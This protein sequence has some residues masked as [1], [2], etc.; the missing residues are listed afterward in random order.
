MKRLYRMALWRAAP[1]SMA[2]SLALGIVAQAPARADA[3]A[4]ELLAKTT[5]A[6]KAAKSLTA[7]ISITMS[8]GA[9]KFAQTGTLRLRKP[10]LAHVEM[11]TPVKMTIM[12]DGKSVYT[13]LADKQYVQQP[14][15]S[16]GMAQVESRV[17]L[18]AA[19][20]FG[21]DSYGF[22]RLS[23]PATQKKYAGKETVGGVAYDVVTV[24]GKTPFVHTLKI[25]IGPDGLIGRSSADVTVQSKKLTQNF[26]WKSLKLNAVPA[27]ASF[28][29]VLPKDA[30]PY[31]PPSQDDYAA[32]LVAV[33]M[34]APVFALPNPTGGTVSLADSTA[35]HKA[36]IVNFWFYG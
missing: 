34:P 10:N 36:V 3:K 29:V 6:Y 33:G 8:Q 35:D 9:Q 7:D 12:S 30:K 27:A 4:D 28:A 17:G 2:A 31:K 23:D 15:D 24:S 32:K 14:V 11:L 25:Y 22:G 21:R 20:F 18:P 16:G 13:V 19:L 1:L 5:A 26:E